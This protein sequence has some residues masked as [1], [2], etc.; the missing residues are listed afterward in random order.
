MEPAN[1]FFT[2]KNSPLSAEKGLPFDK[3]TLKLAETLAVEADKDFLPASKKRKLEGKIEDSQAKKKKLSDNNS[4][5]SFPP[6][7]GVD[8]GRGSIQSPRVGYRGLTPR[9]FIYNYSRNFLINQH[10]GFFSNHPRGRGNYQ[11][12]SGFRPQARGSFRGRPY[13]RG[14]LRFGTHSSGK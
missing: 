13:T 4:L 11:R 6:E 10:G 3:A 12:S 2:L 8:G 7:G 9:G 14:A 1:L 5:Q